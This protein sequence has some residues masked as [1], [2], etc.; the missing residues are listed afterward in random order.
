VA[1][2]KIS[3]EVKSLLDAF[4]KTVFR[5]P[6]D[7]LRELLT[8]AQDACIIRKVQDKDYTDPLISVSADGD[9]RILTVRDN[10][11]GM[12]E[13]HL[14][15]YF[16]TFG[17]SSSRSARRAGGAEAESLVGAFGIGTIAYFI[18]AD[19]IEVIT[20]PIGP[21]SRGFRWSYNGGDNYEIEPEDTAE[22]GTAVSLRM[23]PEFA[24]LTDKNHLMESLL[25]LAPHLEVP[26]SFDGQ[27]IP[28]TRDRS[29]GGETK[30][31]TPVGRR[32]SSLA[33][34]HAVDIELAELGLL[35]LDLSGSW[36]VRDFSEWLND[37]QFAYVRLSAFLL[38]SESDSKL[39]RMMIRPYIHTLMPNDRSAEF[40]T[41]L[42]N[43][44]SK[45][46]DFRI[47]QIQIASP[48][49]IEFVGSLNP[50]KTIADFI[51]SWRAE[52][53]KR[54]EMNLAHKRAL[55][56][57]A[58]EIV[59]ASPNEAF[60]ERFLKFALEEPNQRLT[61]LARDIRLERA[62]WRVIEGGNS[63]KKD[64]DPEDD[65]DGQERE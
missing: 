43:A 15:T 21:E 51:T 3:F 39:L 5:A 49:F 61:V 53:T 32:I 65:K 45:V 56:D 44:R 60:A 22:V 33:S 34:P 38:Y 8:N 57:R 7:V 4:A 31:I 6:E 46:V 42:R 13:E 9:N 36:S 48:G 54:Q 37:L 23:K 12:T 2:N 55:A 17:A 62:S 24:A 47:Q 1:E 52:N 18:V 19:A 30:A 20:R 16:A 14:R 41:V 50:I 59:K 28:G 27:L 25:R 58:A 35:R 29:R 64:R 26:I 40:E 11:L 63:K 10:G